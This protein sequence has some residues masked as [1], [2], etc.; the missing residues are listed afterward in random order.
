M[1]LSL[2]NHEAQQS[3][4]HDNKCLE[5]FHKSYQN[6]NMN[7]LCNEKFIVKVVMCVHIE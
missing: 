5:C 7:M 1:S 3:F 4:S 6:V 2:Q